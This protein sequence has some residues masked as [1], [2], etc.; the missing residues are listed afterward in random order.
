[1]LRRL[2]ALFRRPRVLVPN[3][4]ELAEG[5]GRKVD[6]GDPGAGGLSVLLCRVGG[7]VYAI[8]T[9]CPH[10]G[11]QMIP[12]PLIEGRYATCPLHNYVFDPR[13]GKPVGAV[14]RSARVFSVVERGDACEI[15]L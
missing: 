1:M 11:G 13:N 7:R 8:D 12:G 10:E 15:R 5:E 3:A 9:H 2:L 4:G 14:C 6:I